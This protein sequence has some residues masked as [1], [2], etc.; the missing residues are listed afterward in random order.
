MHITLGRIVAVAVAAMSGIASAATCLAADSADQS[1][2]VT[3][4]TPAWSFEVTP[5]AWLPGIKGDITARDHTVS[6]D[7]SF[8]DIFKAVEFAGAVL[9]LARYERWIV[10][11]QVDFERLSTSKLENAPPRARVDAK[12]TFYTLAAGYT[13]DGWTDQQSFDVLIGLQGFNRDN[14]LSLNTIGNFS[15]SRN[16]VD[17]TVIVRP[18]IRISQ[19]WLF[20]PTAAVGAGGSKYFY[21]L[22]P[23]FQYLFSKTWEV[24]FGYRRMHYTIDSDRGARYDA[25]LSGPLVGFGATF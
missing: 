21:Q 23:Q 6:V 19:R 13:F 20:N 1:P 17:A 18:S 2:L 8:S 11:T 24:R 7:Q 16:T 4:E 9:A 22:Q 10:W 15:Q 14:T 3:G 12:M 5:Y 25:N